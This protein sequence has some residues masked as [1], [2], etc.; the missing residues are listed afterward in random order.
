MGECKVSQKY[1]FWH[2]VGHKI[3]I[4][5]SQTRY[6]SF[7]VKLV[8]YDTKKKLNRV[9]NFRRSVSLFIFANWEKKIIWLELI[10]RYRT[11]VFFTG[12]SF[13]DLKANQ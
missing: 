5:K 10:L 4:S 11:K 2:V 1:K 8:R 12:Y 9:E 7:L 6:Q 3:L 13:H